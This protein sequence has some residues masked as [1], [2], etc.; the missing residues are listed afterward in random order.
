MSAS[1]PGGVSL[2]DSL[3]PEGDHLTTVTLVATIG[4]GKSPG[5]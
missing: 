3:L 5:V 4:S 2:A 1:Q